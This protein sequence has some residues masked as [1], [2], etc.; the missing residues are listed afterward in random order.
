MLRAAAALEAAAAPGREDSRQQRSFRRPLAK[1]PRPKSEE[2]SAR[3]LSDTENRIAVERRRYN[4]M[5]EHYNALI[6]RFPD[7]I[8]ASLIG[9]PR[10]DTI[11]NRTRR[12]ACAEGRPLEDRQ[13]GN[14]P[15]FT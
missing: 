4:E 11:S 2:V 13:R 9:L 6:Q 15:R 5:L 1:L 8:V 10:N 3:R 7:N 12:A 14:R